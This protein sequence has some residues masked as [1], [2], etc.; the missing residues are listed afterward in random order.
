MMHG[1]TNIK[2][3]KSSWQIMRFR[4]TGKLEFSG[5]CFKTLMSSF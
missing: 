4:I 5:P 2:L 3:I 1:T